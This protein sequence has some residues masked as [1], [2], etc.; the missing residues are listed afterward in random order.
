MLIDV[1][2]VLITRRPAT[3]GIFCAFPSLWRRR[4][5]WKRFFSRKKDSFI[6]FSFFSKLKSFLIFCQKNLQIRAEITISRNNAIWYAF[7]SKF[8]TFSHFEKFNFFFRKIHLFFFKKTQSLNVLRNFTILV[9]FYGKFSKI[10]W[11][12]FFTLRKMNE[13]RLKR[14]HNW[15]I[16]GKKTFDFSYLSQRFR[17]H[18]LQAWRKIMILSIQN[19]EKPLLWISFCFQRKYSKTSTASIL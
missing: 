18:I 8:A 13:H 11:K 9:A 5:R 15:Q 3:T 1:S 12:R 16:L 17:S 4:K 10:W 19:V 2:A 6:M 14:G 7:H